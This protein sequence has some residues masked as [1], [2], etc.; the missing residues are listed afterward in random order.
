MDACTQCPHPNDCLKVGA[1]LD[2][3]NA[4]LIASGQFPRRMTPAQANEFT[5]ALREGKTLRR[6]TN[7]GKFGHA[8]VPLRKFKNHCALYPDWGGGSYAARQG[9]RQGG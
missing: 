8:I 2:D 3:I 1:C 7:G 6:I 9:Q 4:P 5:T